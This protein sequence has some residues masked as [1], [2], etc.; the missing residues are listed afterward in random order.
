MKRGTVTWYN[1]QMG[2]GYIED[3]NGKKFIVYEGSIEW[4]NGRLL[5]RGQRVG[6]VAVSDE[7]EMIAVNVIK[8]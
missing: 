4:D 8:N 3:K 1:R 7:G 6:F 2:Y 5:E